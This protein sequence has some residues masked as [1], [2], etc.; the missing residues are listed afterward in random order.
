MTPLRRQL[1]SARAE[2]RRLAYPGRVADAV[3][4]WRNWRR[5]VLVSGAFGAGSLAAAAS[6]VIAFAHIAPPLEQSPQTIVQS[7][8]DRHLPALP[9][10]PLPKGLTIAPYDQFIPEALRQL[11]FPFPFGDSPADDEN[12]QAA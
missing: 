6:I 3:L 5:L 10:P 4:P 1:Q 8:A 12:P 2:Y 9:L 11:K 7:V